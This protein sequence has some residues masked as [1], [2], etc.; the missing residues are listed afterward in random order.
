MILDA[1]SNGSPDGFGIKIIVFLSSIYF[2][3]YHHVNCYCF[4]LLLCYIFLLI[5]REG[6]SLKAAS[7]G[8]E[9]SYYAI[10]Y[11]TFL[12]I[13]VFANVSLIFVIYFYHLL[14]L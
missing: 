13:Y 3:Y 8:L 11:L 4:F 9:A 2:N 6:Y 5:L 10:Y 14:L 7:V 12:L 1:H